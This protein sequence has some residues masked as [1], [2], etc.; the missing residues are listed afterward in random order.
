MPLPHVDLDMSGHRIL[1]TNDDG[2]NAPGIAILEAVARRL[3]DDVWVVA[4]ETEQS[5]AGHSL[6]LTEPLRL[7]DLGNQR[8]AVLGT[9][10]DSVLTGI[11]KAVTG[12]KPTLVLSGVNRGA[13]MAEDVTYSGTV[14][15]AMEGTLLGIPSI[16]LS[17][18]IFPSNEGVDWRATEEVAES[19]IRW[20]V[21]GGWPDD[22]LM[23]VNFP[24]L[25]EGP[26]NGIAVTGQ[27]KRDLSDIVL[28]ER[29]DTRGNAYYWVGYR[30]AKDHLE[31]GTDIKTVREG[32]VSVTPLHLN[33]THLETRDVLSNSLGATGDA[34]T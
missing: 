28:D 1:V 14:A 13:N 12:R 26:I 2:I 29:V 21:S 22:V 24:D 16:A 25:R 20:L 10:T 30:R 19:V 8:F 9:P 32:G 31:D 23:N 33:F 6:T 34:Q 18:A 3:T 5:G 11:R 27:G 4:P 15:A 7:R 17:Q